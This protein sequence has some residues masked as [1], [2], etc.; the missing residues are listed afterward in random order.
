MF[1]S[2]KST[3]VLVKGKVVYNFRPIKG[4][5]F[6][7]H[8]FCLLTLVAQRSIGGHHIYIHFTYVLYRSFTLDCFVF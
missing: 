7:V 5:K 8:N 6:A 2:A 3:S 4:G 1:L